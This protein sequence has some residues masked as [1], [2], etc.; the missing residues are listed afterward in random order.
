MLVKTIEFFYTPTSYSDSGLISSLADTT[1]AA[2]NYSWRNSGT[3]SKTNV[4]A[5]YVN[6]VDKTSETA[7]SNV[8][9]LNELHHV[10]IVYTEPISNDIKLNSSLY[11]SEEALY[12]NIIFYPAA[13][14]ST[15]ALNHYNLYTQNA[16]ESIYANTSDV[17]LTELTPDIYDNDWILIQSS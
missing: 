2:S 16:A 12:K 9:T 3:V 10:V 13:F 11:G 7:V 17:T 5:I 6:G 8:F 14:N 1:Y 15:K 4:A